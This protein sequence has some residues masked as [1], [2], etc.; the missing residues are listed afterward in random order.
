M[1]MTRKG[2]HLVGVVDDGVCCYDL[3]FER[4][5]LLMVMLLMMMMMMI[6]IIIIIIIIRMQKR[7]RR[8]RKIKRKMKRA[9]RKMTLIMIDCG[10]E[11]GHLRIH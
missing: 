5:I 1:L 2:R 6:I 10:V 11:I 4:V 8:R 9:N 3:C 7:R